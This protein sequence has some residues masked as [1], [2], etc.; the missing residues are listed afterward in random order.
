MAKIS[1]ETEKIR[2]FTDYSNFELIDF[3]LETFKYFDINGIKTYNS[4]YIIKGE[5]IKI[6]EY[7][8]Q[9]N[10]NSLLGEL[11][12]DFNNIGLNKFNILQKGIVRIP[13]QVEHTFF[14]NFY[15]NSKKY[16][17][18]FKK[19]GT[20]GYYYDLKT[21]L[22]NGKLIERIKEQLQLYTE[23]YLNINLGGHLK[24]NEN[25]STLINIKGSP[26]FY[27]STYNE[28]FMCRNHMPNVSF[29]NFNNFGNNKIRTFENIET[30]ESLYLYDNNTLRSLG[31]IETIK[32]LCY[33]K[34]S[35]IDSLGNLK[36]VEDTLIIEKC[37]NIK[38]VENIKILGNLNLRSCEIN[39]IKNLNIK[40]NLYINKKF[41]NNF[42]I[43]NCIIAGGV[44]YLNPMKRD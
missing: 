21:G 22:G 32:Q 20:S 37:S 10:L 14:V 3:S 23:L 11:G 2:Y 35:S 26:I 41:K 33:L 18:L 13:I 29:G 7:S 28:Y 39:T 19:F 9:N 40:G 6:E 12:I 8:S 43:E 4:K 17:S 42:V 30:I 34:N 36:L 5:I 15:E 27:Q 1:L 31:S 25:L 16:K 24:V 44:K 38:S